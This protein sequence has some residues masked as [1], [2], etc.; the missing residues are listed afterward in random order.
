MPIWRDDLAM[1][2]FYCGKCGNKYAWQS[3]LAGR[4]VRC[5][6]G[7]IISVS[8]A[9]ETPT[10]L[11]RPEPV[12][13][14]PRPAV[15]VATANEAVAKYPTRARPARVTEKP[16]EEV[17]A[18]RDVYAPILF[19]LMGLALHV[20][21]LLNLKPSI[22][23]GMP[24]EIALMM[25]EQFLGAMIAL[26]GAIASSRILDWELPEFPKLIFKVIAASVFTIAVFFFVQ[27]LDFSREG[28]VGLVVAWQCAMLT[29]WMLMQ[30]FF[31][32]EILEGA[33]TAVITMCT[34]AAGACVMWR[35]T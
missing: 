14:A 4:K 28:W 9:A 25:I 30:F 11:P 1:S 16:P 35:A 20:G 12:E 5:K 21:A 22:S 19:I 27:G 29:C 26:F 31:K 24:T 13:V 32:L 33:L 23:R 34:V 2:Y 17:S 3:A 10:P 6:C 7:E 15:V 8:A 18:V